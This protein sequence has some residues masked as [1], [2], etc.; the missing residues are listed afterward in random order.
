MF[1][2][3]SEERFMLEMGDSQNKKYKIGLLENIEI[4]NFY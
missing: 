3:T 1:H 4:K 2:N